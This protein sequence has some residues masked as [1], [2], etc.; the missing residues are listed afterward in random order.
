MKTKFNAAEIAH[1]AMFAHT[2]AQKLDNLRSQVQDNAPSPT[3]VNYELDS[4][5]QLL[6]Y[7]ASSLKNA[8]K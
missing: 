5:E 2:L 8:A 6:G 7:I 4:A 3:M 1:A